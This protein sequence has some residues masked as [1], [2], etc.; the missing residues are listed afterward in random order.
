[1]GVFMNILLLAHQCKRWRSSEIVD[2][3]GGVHIPNYYYSGMDGEDGVGGLGLVEGEEFYY[4][5]ARV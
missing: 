2:G 5:V 3:R 1:M 4:T